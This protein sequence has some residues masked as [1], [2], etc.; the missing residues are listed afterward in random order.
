MPKDEKQ[1]NVYLAGENLD[2]FNSIKKKL[3]LG[4]DAEVLRACLRFTFE[5]YST[6]EILRSLGLDPSKSDEEIR[7]N[8]DEIK[9]TLERIE[10]P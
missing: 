1:V 4:N 2:M 3:Y 8:L 10:R 9:K 5:N 7:R 6:V